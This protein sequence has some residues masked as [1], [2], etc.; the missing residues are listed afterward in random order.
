M[1]VSVIVCA[2][3]RVLAAPI[4]QL[5]LGTSEHALLIRLVGL[6]VGPGT[7]GKGADSVFR[8]RRQPL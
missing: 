6:A 8:Y 1:G 3:L 4:S 7:G 2:L 5:L